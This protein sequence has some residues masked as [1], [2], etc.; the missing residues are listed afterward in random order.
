MDTFSTYNWRGVDFPVPN[1]VEEYLTWMYNANW[2]TPN[3]AKKYNN[4]RES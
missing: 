4:N 1:H 3:P 2:R